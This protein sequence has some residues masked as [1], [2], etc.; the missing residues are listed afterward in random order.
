REDARPDHP[1]IDPAPRRRDHSVMDRRAFVTAMASMI[2][3]IG[4]ARAS[5]ED[6]R[7]DRLYKMTTTLVLKYY[8]DAK[9]E[10]KQHTIHF[11]ARARPFMVHEQLKTGEWQDA[12]ETIGPQRG[13]VVGDMELRSGKY[14]GAAVSQCAE[15]GLGG[16]PVVGLVANI[17]GSKGH[18]FFLDA[19]RTVLVAAPETRFLIV[20]DGI[21]FE[22]M[23]AR[24]QQMGLP[25]SVHLSGFRRDVPQVMAALDV[26]VLPSTRS[27]GT[28]QV[29]LQAL[30]IGTS[31]GLQRRRHPRA[32]A[33]R[34][35]RSLRAARRLSGAR[36]GDPD[37]APPDLDR[38][39]NLH[40]DDRHLRRRT[41]SRKG[42]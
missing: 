22:E 11:E 30:A 13:G 27:E 9:T 17:R 36:R 24:V 18:N 33:E 35:N 25:S 21:G 41:P 32:G 31:R 6:R 12:R 23:K 42:G 15:L 5:D 39:V 14:L 19:A 8:P 1:S 34:R 2:A 28:S 26:L 29:I 16:A 3:G 37:R 10:F 4:L 20:G 38:I 40:E 7:L